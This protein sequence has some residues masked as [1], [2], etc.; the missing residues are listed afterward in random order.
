MVSP[1]PIALGVDIFARPSKAFPLVDANPLLEQAD[2]PPLG[3]V[4]QILERVQSLDPMIHLPLYGAGSSFG[5][6]LGHGSTEFISKAEDE[7]EYDNSPSDEATPLPSKS[8]L[9]CRL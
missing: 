5:H 9:S 2:T 1:H 3:R 8:S 7:Y 4:R 6:G